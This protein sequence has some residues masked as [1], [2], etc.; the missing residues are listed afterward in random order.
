MSSG[1]LLSAEQLAFWEENG[2]LIL[3]E[4]LSA[5]QIADVLDLVDRQWSARP[6]NAHEV[7]ILSGEY[8]G[9]TF[10]LRD[11]WPELRQNVYK[12]NNLFLNVPGLRRIAYTPVIRAALIDLLQGEP[13]ICNSLN[14][15]RGSQQPM[16]FDTWYMP[17]PV[18]T[19]MVAANIALEPVDG[20]NGPITYYPGS[21]KIPPWRFSDDRLN[22]KDEEAPEMY[23]YLKAEIR[24][25]GLQQ[26]TFSGGAGDVFLWHAHLYH[27]GLPIRDMKRTR[28]S[29]V[30][31]YWRAGDLPPSEV[32]RDS[33]GAYL[34]RTLRGEIVARG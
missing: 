10:P 13:L 28:K 24:G 29:L 26:E 17:P 25:R 12:L 21:H 5:D 30:V 3:R 27:G 14:F 2:F 31:H 7:D 23:D 11:A 1:I 18:D 20:D 34:G 19:R 15:E 9:K 16:H 6:G 32:R 4:A 33:V 8:D 22:F